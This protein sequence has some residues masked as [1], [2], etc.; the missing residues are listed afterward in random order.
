[1]LERRDWTAAAAL[2]AREPSALPWDRFAWPEAIILFAKGVGAVHL[3]DV[4]AALAIGARLDTMERATNAQGEVIF[5]SNIRLLRLALGAWTAQG[6]G[7]SDEALKLL[8]EAATLEDATPKHAVTPAPTLPALEQ[9]GDLQMEQ[10]SAA[11]ALVSYRYA[12]ARYPRRFNALLGAARAARAVDDTVAARG[13]YA[14]LLAVAK[15]G[16]RRSPLDEARRYIT[17]AR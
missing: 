2:V 8:R 15:D 6:A 9:L 3:D 14:E 5:S 11:E 13:Y 17:G 12:L 7:R 10:G 1:M 4:A 16:T